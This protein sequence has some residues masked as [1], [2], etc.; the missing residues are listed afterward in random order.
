MNSDVTMRPIHLFGVYDTPCGS[1][2][3]LR[4]GERERR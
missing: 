4:V 2:R 1:D 3:H